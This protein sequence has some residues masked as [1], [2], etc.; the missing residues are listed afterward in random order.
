MPLIPS[1]PVRY[2]VDDAR[3]PGCY[4]VEEP[5]PGLPP[6][7][8]VVRHVRGVFSRLAA[9]QLYSGSDTGRAIDHRQEW[10]PC[11]TVLGR[12]VLALTGG[13]P[14]LA[15]AVR[16]GGGP[17]KPHVL[18]TDRLRNI[19]LAG[20]T[21]AGESAP[22]RAAA[23]GFGSR[24]WEGVFGTAQFA[25]DR[26]KAEADRREA[27]RVASAIKS[28]AASVAAA[29]KVNPPAKSRP[30]LSAPL[31]PVAFDP[32][33]APGPVAVWTSSVAVSALKAED[34]QAYMTEAMGRMAGKIAGRF[35]LSPELAGELAELAPVP[36]AA[37]G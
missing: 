3:R 15:P 29:R 22:V 30:V 33:A 34:F 18:L 37:G 13:R 4:P 16:S 35:A 12:Y 11:P 24:Q 17:V 10:R 14:W 5:V 27:A 1:G 9:V 6:G 19:A 2:V 20:V 7:R 25:A 26:A 23:V 21:P 8:T 28:K 32:A 31:P 36:P